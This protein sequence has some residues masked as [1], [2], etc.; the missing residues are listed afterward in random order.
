M[1]FRHIMI[2]TDGS[3]LADGAVYHALE[4]AKSLGAKVTAVTVTDMLPTG[5]Y[6]PIPW[7][8]DIERYEAAAVTSANIILEKVSEAARRLGVPCTTQHIA[9]QLP[10]EGIH[11]ACQ[12]HGCDLIVMASH[13]RR[14]FSK[15]MLGS[16]ANKV[17]TLSSVPVLVCR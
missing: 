15:L 2:A 6:S 16:Q 13:G 11:A 12:E 3:E 17:V 8:A 7:P 14:G 10:A 9:D 1:M 4:L 5:P